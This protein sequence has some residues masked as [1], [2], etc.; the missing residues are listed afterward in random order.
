MYIRYFEIDGEGVPFEFPVKNERLSISRAEDFRRIPGGP[1]AYWVSNSF[2]RNF[3]RGISI[4]KIS[5]FTGSQ[6]KTAD[7]EK[8]LRYF[9]EVNNKKIGC[10]NRWVVYAK[11]GE[12]GN[13]NMMDWSKAKYEQNKTSNC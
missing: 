2:I 8:Y 13:L 5:D 7:N 1:I 4:E 6:N 10:E 9:W 12:T 11:G 3:E